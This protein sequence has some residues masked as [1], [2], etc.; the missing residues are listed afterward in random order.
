MARCSYCTLEHYL[1]T[2]TPIVSASA[3]SKM[4]LTI[5]ELSDSG[6]HRQMTTSRSDLGVPEAWLYP[7]YGF[8]RRPHLN[9]MAGDMRNHFYSLFHLASDETGRA[10][11]HRRL[12]SGSLCQASPCQCP[13]LFRM[14]YVASADQSA[15]TLLQARH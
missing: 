5:T 7:L 11:E 2:R 10:S 4:L 3:L 14:P 12:E 9:A 13:K 6:T 1:N 15:K 8:W